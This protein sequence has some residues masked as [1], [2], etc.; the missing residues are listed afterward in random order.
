MKIISK[1]NWALG[2][3]WKSLGEAKDWAKTHIRVCENSLKSMGRGSY[4][5]S[6]ASYWYSVAKKV[7]N[8]YVTRS[9]EELAIPGDTYLWECPRCDEI[10]LYVKGKD[11]P[12]CSCDF[13]EEEE[14]ELTEEEK[15]AILLG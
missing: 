13:E 4:L 6:G 14:E 11:I 12:Q 2:K 9:T 7:L 15:E 10:H 3:N 1:L 5:T 8:F